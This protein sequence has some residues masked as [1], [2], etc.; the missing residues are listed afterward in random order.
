MAEPRYRRRKEDR[1][2]E[3]AQAAFELFAEKGYAATRVE[4]VAK[5]A[6]VSKGLTYVYFNT[7]ADLFRAVVESVVIPRVEAL[8]ESVRTSELSGEDFLRGPMAD[9]LKA[10]PG[11]PVSA[12]VRVVIAEGPRYPELVEFYW[13]NVIHPGMTA[14]RAVMQRGVEEGTFRESAVT[15]LPQLV[16]APAMM[17]VIWKLLLPT[18]KLNS[19]ELI[20]TQIELILEELKK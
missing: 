2:Q 9:F 10:L 15:R 6:G 4:E 8:G 19:D 17:S 13:Q 20:D 5:R 11:S 14:I 12:V 7:K 18:K 1:P 3:I 16:M